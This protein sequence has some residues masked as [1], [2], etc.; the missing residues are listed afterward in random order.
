MSQQTL[1]IHL[2]PYLD[3][4]YLLDFGQFTETTIHQLHHEPLNTGEAESD[5]LETFLLQL[6][7]NGKNVI[8]SIYFK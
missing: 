5:G 7:K 1:N 4:N 2:F 6:N 8:C 3:I